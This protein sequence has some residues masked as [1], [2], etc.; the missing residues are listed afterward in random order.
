[1][2]KASILIVEDEAI[3]AE[4]LGVIPD[5]VRASLAKHALPG[6]R[7][8][9][10]ER[11]GDVFRDPATWPAVS[12]AT[13]GT[14]DTDPLATWWEGMGFDERRHALTEIP[15]LRA[16]ASRRDVEKFGPEVHDA[17]LDAL[18]GAGSDWLL[19]PIQDVLGTRERVNTPATVGAANWSYR[20]AS[21]IEELRRDERAMR[22]FAVVQELAT[23]H[24]R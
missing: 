10:W 12:L 2:S 20:L 8:L 9:F 1:M 21:T 22:R 15:S 11:D 3:V 16:V 23:K 7:V 14:H 19:L 24:R 6:Y 4:D 17:I 5:F 13:T 18:Y